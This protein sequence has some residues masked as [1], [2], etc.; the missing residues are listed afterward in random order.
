M[1]DNVCTGIGMSVWA[2]LRWSTVQFG[3][4]V[5]FWEYYTVM[6]KAVCHHTDA[7]RDDPT[8]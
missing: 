8:E 5:A 4:R 1:E 6:K 3:L 2:S 7:T